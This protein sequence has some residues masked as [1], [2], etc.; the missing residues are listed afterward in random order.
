MV[1]SDEQFP[2]SIPFKKSHRRKNLHGQDNHTTDPISTP[3]PLHRNCDVCDHRQVSITSPLEMEQIL[4]MLISRDSLE[5][6]SPKKEFG[7]DDQ[8]TKRLI[9]SKSQF[10]SSIP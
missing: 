3:V 5:G 9:R 4:H 8:T 6:K 10:P 2:Q 1:K 7:Q